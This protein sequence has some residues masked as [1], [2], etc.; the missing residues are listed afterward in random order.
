MSEVTKNLHVHTVVVDGQPV[1]TSASEGDPHS[2]TVSGVSGSSASSGPGHKHSFEIKGESLTS[3][4][5][6]PVSNSNSNSD[7]SKEKETK[8]KK[9][10]KRKPSKKVL[11]EVFARGV[12]DWESADHPGAS[13]E[14][15]GNLRVEKFLLC[16][17]DSDPSY[18][19]EDC[20]DSDLIPSK[21]EE[22]LWSDC[23][24]E[25]D[26]LAALQKRAVDRLSRS[27]VVSEDTESLKKAHR[28]LYKLYNVHFKDNTCD[29]SINNLC[30]DEV[31]RSA[32]LVQS[33]LER[34]EELS[35]SDHPLY[36]EALEWRQDPSRF[37]D[38]FLGRVSQRKDGVR[39]DFSGSKL[40]LKSNRQ[41]L[42]KDVQSV[43]K[44]FSVD[45]SKWHLSM[46]EP[47]G[48]E[49]QTIPD[50]DV[51]EFIGMCTLE[52]GA[53][54][55]SFTEYFAH[56][57][58]V[59]SGVLLVGKEKVQLREVRTPY[60][61]TKQAVLDEWMPSPG[62]SGLPISLELD[63]PKKYRYW[64]A[65]NDEDRRS[66][67]DS[68]VKFYLDRYE[69]RTELVDNKFRLVKCSY[70]IDE[71]EPVDPHHF[72]DALENVDQVSLVKSWLSKDVDSFEYGEDLSTD[73]DFL[74]WTS[75][76]SVSL[77]KY[78]TPFKVRDLDDSFRFVSTI[79][80]KNISRVSWEHS[81]SQV[82]EN[83]NFLEKKVSLCKVDPDSEEQFVLGVVLSPEEIDSQN[84]IISEDEIR[85]TAHT[86]MAE[87]K[88]IGFMHTDIINDQTQI[89]E[90]YLA[91]VDMDV[92]GELIR[93]GAWVLGVRVLS[94]SLWEGIKSGKITGFSIGGTAVREPNS[95]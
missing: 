45:G 79:P 63:I 8:R 17:N 3:S 68:L 80:L 2:H 67:R 88:N 35:K 6:K 44:Y 91:P 86:F 29:V 75:D 76:E 85:K 57:S 52:K 40:L 71:V 62:E 12:K 92:N 9:P 89:L 27:F 13:K 38:K 33:E 61:L 55:D 22:D 7:S 41:D 30:R 18:S 31:V 70:H 49:Y 15:W 95:V 28:L 11:K 83:K 46:R 19:A 50:L 10:Y 64:R 90:S 73:S 60:V 54:T 26:R 93:K 74:V 1:V 20:L 47:E 43:S 37:A 84:D 65:K 36:K 72:T 66:I 42:P 94:E 51:G 77:E 4:G 34:R 23:D 32:A 56:D 16:W 24:I 58:N 14:A 25:E 21:H 78:G 81:S 39:L 48:V 5:P 82:S 53:K 87:F 59:F 69:C